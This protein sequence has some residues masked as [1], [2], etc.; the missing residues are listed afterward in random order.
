[1]SPRTVLVI[2][3]AQD[4]T[5]DLVVD[6]LLT[7]GAEIARIDTADFPDT[8]SLAATPDRID[9]PGWLCARG[10]R[11]DL[12]LVR[13]V[14]RRSP[15][16]FAFPDGMSAPERQFATLE[17]VYG[18]GGVLSAQ[19]W[20]W[21]DHPSAVADASYKPRQLRV[22][23]QCG[24]NVPRSL[25]TNVGARAREFAA[26]VG[27]A[28]VYKSLSTGVVTEA[29][30]LRIV[31]TSRLTA[32]DLDDGAI[33]LCCHLFQEW[34]PKAFDVR[35][36]VVGDRFFAVAVHSG[37]PETE[38]DWRCRYDELRYEVRE[39][40]GEV[41]YGVRAYLREFGLIFGAFDFSVTPD[42]RWWFLECNPA[43]QW[44]WIAEETGLP[45]A[46]AIADEL[47]R[48]V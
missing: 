30:E 44:G 37:S 32:D 23:A 28:V 12:E 34:V 17:S 39:A 43:G 40:P 35:L 33:A 15:A 14:Y 9:S 5:A 48:A 13:S 46:G 8:L 38:V 45:I 11:I 27:D 25:V 47:V 7:R 6:A 10:R 31:Y 29:D 42:G 19:P 2:A 21:I 26:E 22:A 4:G 36:T 41:R 1:M 20:R 18:L 24:L 3:Q 16:R